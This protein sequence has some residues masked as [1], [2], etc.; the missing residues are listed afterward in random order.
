MTRLQVREALVAVAAVALGWWAHGGP[1][2]QAAP[3]SSAAAFQ[4]TGIN[5]A[6]VADGIQPGGSHA[7]RLPGSDHRELPCDLLLQNPHTA[8]GRCD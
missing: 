2:V 1:T 6:T 5:P 3:V 8:T 7:V 4:F